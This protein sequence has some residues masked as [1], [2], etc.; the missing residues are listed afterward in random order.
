MHLIGEHGPEHV[1][2]GLAQARGS[3]EADFS[4]IHL[5]CFGGYLRTCEWLHRVANGRFRLNGHGGFDVVGHG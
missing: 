1:V 4:G 2:R 3:G 5:F